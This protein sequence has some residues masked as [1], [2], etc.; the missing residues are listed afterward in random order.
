MYITFSK[1]QMAIVS[2]PTS[3]AGVNFPGQIGSTASGPLKS[4]YEG[5]GVK[6]FK[7]PSDLA[8]DPT[9]T[10][11]VMFSVKDVIPAGW[12]ASQEQPSINLSGAVKTLSGISKLAANEI[13][14]TGPTGLAL[15]NQVNGFEKVTTTL[16]NIGSFLS[17]GIAIDSKKTESTAVVS[18]YMPDTVQANYNSNYTELSLTHD[19]GML[20]T[21][22]Q[23]DQLAGKLNFNSV[24]DLTKSIGQLASTD[25]AVIKLITDV[26]GTNVIGQGQDLFL[27]GMGYAINPQVQMIYKGITLRDFTLSFTLTPKTAQDSEQIKKI[28]EIFK[29][30]AAPTLQASATTSTNS[31]F[32][33]PPSI[34]NVYFM[35]SDKENQYLP[36]YGDCV[37]KNIDVNYTPNGWASYDSGAPVQTSL[38]L[39]FEEIEAIDRGKLKSGALSTS[40]GLR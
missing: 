15:V 8:T 21:L 29:I 16:S 20:G 3:V 23:I 7:Y 40:G 1:N 35:M 33:I 12:V 2:F 25:P 27:K 17:Q 28:V 39:Q 22:R 6:T 11:Y 19:L 18:L 26:L 38:T 9:K 4:L 24:E 10:H 36:R 14:K 31:M 30:C 13:S 34:F 32:L 5:T 37:L